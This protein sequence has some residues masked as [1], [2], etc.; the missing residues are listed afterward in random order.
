MGTHQVGPTRALVSAIVMFA[1]LAAASGTAEAQRKERSGKEVVDGVCASCHATGKDKAPRIGDAKAWSARASQGLSALTE[2]AIKGIRKMP[3]HGGSANVSDIEIER[4]ITTMVN[5]SG[6]HWIEP[7][8]GATPAV[9][10]TSEAVVQA[11]CAKCHRS[12]E[13]GAPKIGDRTAWIPRLKKGL[14]PLVASAIHGHGAMPARG[15]M[16]DLSDQEMRGAIIYM[17]NYGVP[18]APPPPPRA[19]P[20]DPRH[21]L[22]SGTD[23]YLGMIRAEAMRSAQTG[24]N[25][26]KLDIPFGKGYYHVNISLA[27]AGSHVPVTD[28]EVKVQ[29]T[30]GMSIDSKTLGLVAVNNTVSYGSFFRLSSG[31][32]YKITADIRRPGAAPIEAKFEVKAP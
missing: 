8:G 19:P 7:V 4:A 26:T 3:A 13:A 18:P 5:E 15:G 12:G 14:D 25:T 30:D 28:A 2:H 9:V 1:A 21:K 10:R 32:V 20:P 16:P 17:F 23:I 22:I 11:Q 6:G 29:V 31:S 24:K 27:D